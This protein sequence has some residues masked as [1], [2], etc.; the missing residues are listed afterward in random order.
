MWNMNRADQWSLL[1]VTPACFG[2]D[3][4]VERVYETGVYLMNYV[5]TVVG[6]VL[7]VFSGSQTFPLLYPQ[8]QANI[9]SFFLCMTESDQRVKIL[10]NPNGSPRN[11][12]VRT[13]FPNSRVQYV[14][15]NCDQMSKN[16]YCIYRYAHFYNID[17]W[18]Q[19][20]SK[21]GNIKNYWQFLL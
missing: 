16:T 1:W 7:P 2:E 11:F 6:T 12:T 3:A 4:S 15:Q 13:C 17:K 8:C 21:G 19:K 10:K 9:K 20:T 18:T 14:G 5:D